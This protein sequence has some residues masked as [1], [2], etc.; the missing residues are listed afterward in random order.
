M[1]LFK[2]CV[3]F[4]MCAAAGLTNSPESHTEI[5][6][7]ENIKIEQPTIYE[8]YCFIKVLKKGSFG[9]CLLGRKRD[10]NKL[11]AVK[12]IKKRILM[13]KRVAD[14]IMSEI[15]I[16]RSILQYPFIAAINAYYDS[17]SQI[18]LVNEYVNGGDLF[19]HLQQDTKFNEGRT[20]FY[21]AEVILALQFLHHH[22]IVH[23]NLK[24]KN[25]LLDSKGH[26]KVTDFVLSNV[27]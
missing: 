23:H 27:R 18:F 9:K 22:G 4:L 7:D 19:F 8:D 21:A 17:P 10:D 20:A 25:V 14:P 5:E 11:Y 1:F 24:L 16:L 6:S 26:C 3:A 13:R 12:V 15:R 2:P